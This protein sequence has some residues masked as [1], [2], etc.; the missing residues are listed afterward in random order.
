MTSKEEDA[1]AGK[2]R[3]ASPVGGGAGSQTRE[4]SLSSAGW[5]PL[6]T[7]WAKARSASPVGGGDGSQ[8]KETLRSR[9]ARIPCDPWNVVYASPT[10]PA[11]CCK[12]G[13]GWVRFHLD[14]DE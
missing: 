11:V 10:C 3:S 4:T 2:A 7:V 9:L 12:S 6:G 14:L 5:A 13:K 8:T 1:S